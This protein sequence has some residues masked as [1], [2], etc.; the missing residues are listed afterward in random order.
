MADQ[1]IPFSEVLIGS[2]A[3]MIRQIGQAVADA[4]NALDS[5]A[6]QSQKALDKSFPE[7]AQ[8]G[9][10]VTWYQIPSVEAELKVVVHLER[11]SREGRSQVGVFL[12]PFNAKYNSAFTFTAEGTSTV[13]VRIV[14]VPPPLSESV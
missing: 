3:Q 4:Q 11:T 2:P 5:A 1:P 6:I 13:K 14:P 12:A 10:Q 8:L 7:L 9:Y